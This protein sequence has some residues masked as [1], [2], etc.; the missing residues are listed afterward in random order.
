M[1]TDDILYE[2]FSHTR[3]RRDLQRMQLSKVVRVAGYISMLDMDTAL[4]A[5]AL[6]ILKDGT[7]AFSRAGTTIYPCIHT[8]GCDTNTIYKQKYPDEEVFERI[9]RPI[10]TISICTDL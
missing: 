5:N 6:Q 1:L 8:Y 7:V 3:D 4:G 10:F 2:V 9:H